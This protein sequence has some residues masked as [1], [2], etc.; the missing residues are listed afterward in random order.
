MK[1]EKKKNDKL[2]A[3]KFDY[4]VIK[5][6]KEMEGTEQLWQIVF[7]NKNQDVVNNALWFLS[8]IHTTLHE[9][10]IEKE[11]EF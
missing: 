10:I 3:E 8:K 6:P 7:Q 2:N 1:N 5:D 4:E 11:Q 9:S